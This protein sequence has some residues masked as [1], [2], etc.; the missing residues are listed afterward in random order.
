[1]Q[2]IGRLP[3]KNPRN[4]PLSGHFEGVCG[5]F[6]LS[7]FLYRQRLVLL[8]VRNCVE[9]RPQSLS[10]ASLS[11]KPVHPPAPETEVVL[12][13]R[14][15]TCEDIVTGQPQP[16]PR[17]EIVLTDEAGIDRVSTAILPHAQRRG[18]EAIGI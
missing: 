16:D 15:E 11:P 1:F 4:S 9:S 10:P 14:P 7:H 5:R 6:Y 12:C 2:K 8:C 3:L 13:R 18:S 17:G